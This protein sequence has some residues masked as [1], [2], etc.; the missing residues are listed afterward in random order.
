MACGK[1]R[2]SQDAQKTKSRRFNRLYFNTAGRERKG[3]AQKTPRRPMK[4][5][6]SAEAVKIAARPA[7]AHAH[8]PLAPADRAESESGRCAR[9]VFAPAARAAEKSLAHAPKARRAIDAYAGKSCAQQCNFLKASKSLRRPQR[10]NKRGAP[11]PKLR[12]KVVCSAFE[13]G[14]GPHFARP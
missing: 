14:R 8:P 6:R 3:G 5:R 4:R 12:R 11:R 9:F 1:S 7:G 13:T 10:A 2:M